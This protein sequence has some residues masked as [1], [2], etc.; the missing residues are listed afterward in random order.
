MLKTINNKK[1]LIEDI[2]TRLIKSLHF[3]YPDKYEDDIKKT[4]NKNLNIYKDLEY[5]M[6][7][8][9]QDVFEEDSGLQKFQWNELTQ[10]V[11][12]YIY[13][14]KLDRREYYG[15]DTKPFKRYRTELPVPTTNFWNLESYPRYKFISSSFESTYGYQSSEFIYMSITSELIRNDEKGYT[16]YE[17]LVSEL[18]LITKLTDPIFKEFIPYIEIYDESKILYKYC[19]YHDGE[20]SASLLYF[21]NCTCNLKLQRSVEKDGSIKFRLWH[22]DKQIENFTIDSIKEAINED[23]SKDKLKWATFENHVYVQ[24]RLYELSRTRG[25]PTPYYEYF[26]D[27]LYRNRS[28]F[29]LNFDE[30]SDIVYGHSD[31]HDNYFEKDT[32]KEYHFEKSGRLRAW[33]LWTWIDQKYSLKNVD[34]KLLEEE[35][36]TLNK[37]AENWIKYDYNYIKS[38]TFVPHTCLDLGAQ[39]QCTWDLTE[40]KDKSYEEMM[41]I[42]TR[43][44]HQFRNWIDKFWDNEIL[45]VFDKVSNFDETKPWEQDFS[46]DCAPGQVR[47]G[48]YFKHICEHI[49]KVPYYEPVS[50]FFGCWT[51]RVTFQNKKQR[52]EAYSY[53]AGLSKIGA[54]R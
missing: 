39:I 5:P 21:T 44:M 24:K 53:L 52:D 16:D 13:K 2:K 25:K 41:E 23:Y 54:I 12:D 6:I 27:I 49:L 48:E 20:V 51:W 22:G 47:P 29:T 4:V 40:L 38:I 36:K 8:F 14:C 1:E 15:E 42:T 35:F 34:E 43:L 17:Y 3:T 28:D 45:K 11:H 46:I 18:S 50:T 32:N 37:I 33:T 30:P 26:Y 31:T 7:V 9:N 10:R 19:K